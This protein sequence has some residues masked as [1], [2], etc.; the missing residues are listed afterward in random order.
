[1]LLNPETREALE[2]LPPIEE[3]IDEGIDEEPTVT[4]GTGDKDG[5]QGS[6][7]EAP[8]ERQ[9]EQLSDALGGE[10]QD[11]PAPTGDRADEPAGGQ[12]AA[13]H[14][15]G[16]NKEAGQNAQG[17]DE[18]A[19]KAATY[20]TLVKALADNPV[21]FVQNLLVNLTDGQ[22][23]AVAGGIGQGA[24]VGAAA[25]Q[26]VP[27]HTADEGWDESTLTAPERWLKGQ[28]AVI[29]DLPKFAA[30]V[31]QTAQV[32]ETH[33]V[34]ALNETAALRA[35]VA[36][37]QELVGLQLPEAKFAGAAS[38]APT[39]D[40]KAHKAYS[41]QALLAAR[42]KKASQTATPKTPLNSGGSD[43]SE[44]KGD[45]FAALFQAVKRRTAA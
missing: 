30:A 35:Q 38:G 21:A 40:P 18:L 27:T 13:E 36:A 4:L 5:N 34:Q 29:A 45:S 22:R 14:P 23:A 25:G 17:A 32:H 26:G 43:L 42:A 24:A 3:I 41:E 33:I 15:D 9:T 28:R 8:G 2:K 10:R 37:L 20:D 11:E 6:A 44:I 31:Q 19:T 12:R 7:G 1:M 39:L 16:Q